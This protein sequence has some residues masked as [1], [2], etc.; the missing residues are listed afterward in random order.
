VVPA[1]DPAATLV[2]ARKLYE[3]GKY[4]AAIPLLASV[5]AA[6][7][8][9]VEALGYLGAAYYQ[10]KKLD[11]AI[12]IYEVYSRLLPSDMRTVEFIEEMK[13]ERAGAH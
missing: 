10:V 13:K 9:N 2:E 11:D 12:A 4:A 6:E 3:R 1:T 8:D 7:P 5:V